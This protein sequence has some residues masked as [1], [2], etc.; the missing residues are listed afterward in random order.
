VE[1]I[2]IARE[3]PDKRMIGQGKLADIA[4]T[5]LRLMGLPIPEGMTADNLIT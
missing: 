2:Y 1:C 5:V 4:P 3:A